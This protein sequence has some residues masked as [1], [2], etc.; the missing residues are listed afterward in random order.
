[1]KQSSLVFTIGLILANQAAFANPTGAQVVQGTASFTNPSTHVLNVTNSRNAVINW[2]SF[3]IGAGQTTNFIQPSTSSSVL[4]R[5][6]SN[7]PSQILG[8][9]NSN[10]K[11]FLINQHGIL[12][13]EGAHINTG[14]FFASTLNITDTDFLNGKLKFSGGGQGDIDNQGYIHAGD[15]GNIV[16]IAPNIR[17]GGVIEVDNGHIVLAAGQ[18]ITIS[19]LENPAIQFEVSSSQNKV[20]NLGEIIANRGAASL[21]AGTLHHSGSIRA[22]GL[23]QDADGSI[24]L[25]ATDTNT[26]SGSV[27]VSGEQGGYVEILGETVSVSDGAV[28]DASGSN[29]GGEILIGGDQQGLNPAIKNATSTTIASGAQVHADGVHQGNGGRVIVFAENDVHVHGEVT[30]R[31]G[32]QGGDGGFIET[33]GLQQLDITAV[34]D[35]SAAQGVAGEW[36]I[37]PNNITIVNGTGSNM[38]SAV[39][40]GTEEFSST[41][42]GAILD[43]NLIDAALSAGNNVTITTGTSGL[44]SEPGD[45]YVEADLDVILNN[46]DVSLTLNAHNDIVFYTQEIFPIDFIASGSNALDLEL[47][48]DWDNNQTGRVVF[49]TGFSNS[50]PITID[51]N[52]GSFSVNGDTS[53]SGINTVNINN[54]SWDKFDSLDVGFGATLAL[55]AGA[56]TLNVNTGSILYGG[57]SISGNVFVDGGSIAGGDGVS[58]FGNLNISGLLDFNS[59]LLYSVIGG[60]ST[61]WESSRVTAS[62]ITVD[63]GDVMLVWQDESIP[64]NIILGTLGTTIPLNLLGCTGTGCLTDTSSGSAF[65][66]VINPMAMTGSLTLTPGDDGSLTYGFSSIDAGANFATWSGNPNGDWNVASN[67][68]SGSVPNDTDYVFIQPS[69]GAVTVNLTDDRT[70]A[71]LQVSGQLNINAGNT[72]TVNGDVSVL[73]SYFGPGGIKLADANSILDLAGVLYIGPSAFAY[74]EQGTI[75]RDMVNWG[76][77]HTQAGT[78]FQLD[79]NLVNQSIIAL[80][81]R[82]GVNGFT[83][84]GSIDNNGILSFGNAAQL[85][86]SGGLSLNTSS[87]SAQYVGQGVLSLNAGSSFDAGSGLVD[88]SSLQTFNASNSSVF[89]VQN[90][91]FPATVNLSNSTLQGGGILTLEAA[92]QLNILQSSLVDGVTVSNL[93]NV[94]VSD[95]QSLV[96]QNAIFQNS[97]AGTLTGSGEIYIPA[98]SSLATNNGEAIARIILDGG[99]LNANNFIYGG[100]LNW[101][102]GLITGSGFTNQGMFVVGVDQGSAT[103]VFDLSALTFVNDGDIGIASGIFNTGQPLIIEAGESLQGFGTFNGN[104]FNQAGIVSPGRNDI[105]NDVYQTGT[106]T[107]NGNYTQGANGVLALDLDS[108]LG[109]LLHDRL[110]VTSQLTADGE[111]AFGIINNKSV[112]EIALLI[113][114]SFVPLV[115]SDFAGR[116]S[117]VSIPPGLNFTLSDTGV[118]TIT[119]NVEFL[120]QLANELEVLLGRDGLNHVEIVRA[121]KFIDRRFRIS[122]DEED[123][124][125]GAPRLV[126]K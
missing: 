15:N 69:D 62:Q 25:V 51:T 92:T 119:S 2:Q 40:M 63:G 120:N 41:D 34:P 46:G 115:A 112:A 56:G 26:V 97:G 68:F 49:D 65:S 10:G 117:S 96:L 83:G 43:V 75:T 33:S 39:V 81:D 17:N 108:T 8:N 30:A 47:N 59:G 31:G 27:D 9:L 126:C 42:D 32:S 37:D 55:D 82:V 14:G 1:M 101:R 28:I 38:I 74:L 78:P 70:V 60:F 77:V 91:L 80:D 118:I 85:G 123:E 106:L 98:G 107:I 93:G 19:S 113:D 4:N 87:P 58:S 88:L 12:V 53:V 20:T 76:R 95:G 90:V 84:V 105:L 116:F 23:V 67:W 35:A 100:N 121:M 89:N 94:D 52:G 50:F 71:G 64:Q 44:D 45:I 18:S 29:S 66:T 5:V 104:V 72:L 103:D 16:L 99:T 54:T 21:F 110:I 24:R 22:S 122:R 125:D 6:I 73:S 114:Q 7:N 79:G 111:V 11:V 61:D 57:G 3:N 13:G 86:L 109:G 48:P 124:E 36:L 102:S